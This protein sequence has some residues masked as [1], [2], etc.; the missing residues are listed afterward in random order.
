MNGEDVLRRPVSL[1]GGHAKAILRHLERRG[2]QGHDQMWEH[3]CGDDG[4]HGW[5]PETFDSALSELLDAS[6]VDVTDQRFHLAMRPP[7]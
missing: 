2:A 7:L 3:F 1:V 4:A 6:L 5:Y